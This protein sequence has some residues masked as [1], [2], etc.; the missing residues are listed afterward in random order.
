M[1]LGKRRRQEE[2]GEIFLEEEP[3]EEEESE[4]E[5]SEEDEEEEEEQM[6]Y[7]PTRKEFGIVTQGTSTRDF[8]SLHDKIRFNSELKKPIDRSQ[9]IEAYQNMKIEDPEKTAAGQPDEMKFRCLP[10]RQTFRTIPDSTKYPN[11]SKCP[12]YTKYSK[13]TKCCELKKP[14]NFFDFTQPYKEDTEFLRAM[15]DSIGNIENK[16]A[17]K[18]IFG[19]DFM[20]WYRK[21]KI[22][23]SFGAT[24]VKLYNECRF[25]DIFLQFLFRANPTL[26][27]TLDFDHPFQPVTRGEL[28]IFNKARRSWLLTNVNG[29]VTNVHTY[30]LNLMRQTGVDGTLTFT[31]RNSGHPA[32]PIHMNCSRMIHNGA[33]GFIDVTNVPKL[34]A[35]NDCGFHGKKD[36]HVEAIGVISRNVSFYDF[37]FFLITSMPDVDCKFS[38]LVDNGA[39]PNGD[40]P[41]D[42][43]YMRVLPFYH[44]FDVS[45]FAQDIDR[46]MEPILALLRTEL[47]F[48][49]GPYIPTRSAPVTG[50]G[51]VGQWQKRLWER[52]IRNR[53]KYYFTLNLFTATNGNNV[54][55]IQ[56]TM[57]VP[58]DNRA[59]KKKK[60]DFRTV[61]FGSGEKE[62]EKSSEEESSSE[63]DGILPEGDTD[64][65]EDCQL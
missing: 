23:S 52:G 41:V 38:M 42:F 49:H 37:L 64:I 18:E 50:G 59:A 26:N 33:G 60:Y 47:P 55:S 1:S 4:E 17:A 46:V 53:G 21:S 40:L 28:Q 16:A 44:C 27:V 30:I 58:L 35:A 63:S 43:L 39:R 56:K 3:E 8:L 9:F 7:T 61:F 6:P 19:V 45:R 29:P 36:I 32:Q 57:R 10:T 51:P 5:E 54:F 20:D 2:E 14:R 34:F 31:Y 62:E 24:G 12:P 25:R 65:D 11:P 13:S 22:G 48:Q 15:R